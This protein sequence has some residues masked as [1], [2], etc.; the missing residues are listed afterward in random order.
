MAG[1]SFSYSALA[2]TGEGQRLLQPAGAARKL[3]FQVGGWVGGWGGR[4]MHLG[5]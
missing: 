3:V 4:C 5:C 1:G 2:V